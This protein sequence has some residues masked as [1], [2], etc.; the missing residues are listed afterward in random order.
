M[1]FGYDRADLG[2]TAISGS[3]FTEK[4]CAIEAEKLLVLLDC[5]HAGGIAEAKG[6]P[7]VKSPLPPSVLAE[8]GDS[9]GRV[10]IAS[11]RKDEVSW[12]GTP[13][14]VFTAAILEGLSGYGA[15]ER[16]GFARVLDLTMYA[17]RM[18]PNRTNDKQHPIVKVSNLRDN[19]ALAYYAAGD[20]EPKSLDWSTGVSSISSE[21]QAAQIDT[22]RKMLANYREN[23]LLIEERMSEYVEYHEVPLQLVKSRM[24]AEQNIANL[25]TKLGIRA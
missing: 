10:V 25:E 12:T 20:K 18:V 6:L 16:D 8:L 22:W 9:S 4:L 11:S 19:F 7:D 14:S 17:G 3:L 24:K 15:F 13:Y 5:C 23:L 21:L 1:P 2:N